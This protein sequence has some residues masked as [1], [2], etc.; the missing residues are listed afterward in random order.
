MDSVKQELEA[1]KPAL[2]DIYRT[3]LRPKF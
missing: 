3:S 2:K 1:D